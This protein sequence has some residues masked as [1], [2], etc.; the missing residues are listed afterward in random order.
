LQ[1]ESSP[2]ATS[3]ISE[4]ARDKLVAEFKYLRAHAHAPVSTFLDYLRFNFVIY[5]VMDI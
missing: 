5:S 3:T 1:N 4:K 2:I